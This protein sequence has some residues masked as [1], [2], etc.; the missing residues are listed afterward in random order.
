MGTRPEEDYRSYCISP[1]IKHL[2][3][4]MVSGCMA[5]DVTGR[6]ELAS[7]K[8]NGAKYINK[9]E[10]KLLPSAVSLFSDNH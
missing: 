5:S 1:T 8:M 6:P 10:K 9:L 3:S 7:R 2:Q 4:I